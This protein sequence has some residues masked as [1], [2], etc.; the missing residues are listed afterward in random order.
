MINR[1][2]TYST[3]KGEEFSVTL[4]KEYKWYFIMRFLCLLGIHHYILTH[5]FGYDYEY[6]CYRCDKMR[7]GD[8]K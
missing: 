1:Y 8:I 3:I 4:V 6:V 2:K 5:G 7:D